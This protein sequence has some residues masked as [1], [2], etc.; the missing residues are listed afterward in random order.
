MILYW[1]LV[2]FKSKNNKRANTKTFF[3]FNLHR[4]S[5]HNKRKA[6][7]IGLVRTLEA[8]ESSGYS[9][10]ARLFE[11]ATVKNRKKRKIL[12]DK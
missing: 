2:I 10:Y 4:H 5:W 6:H 12:I 3:G 9:Q 11:I 7:S 8:T 1:I